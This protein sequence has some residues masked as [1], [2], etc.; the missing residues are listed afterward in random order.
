MRKIFTT[1]IAA[2]GLI[3]FAAAAQAECSGH[4][5]TASNDSTIVTTDSTTTTTKPILQGQSGG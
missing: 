3:G 1:F 5:N 4:L 2:L